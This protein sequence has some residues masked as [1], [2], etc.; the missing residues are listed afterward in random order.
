VLNAQITILS[1][2][3]SDIAIVH[4]ANYQF[5]I[6]TPGAEKLNFV[7]VLPEYIR[8]LLSSTRELIS[9]TRYQ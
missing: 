7:Q 3:N 6:I 1:D 2:T 5:K 8:L 4:K 9:S